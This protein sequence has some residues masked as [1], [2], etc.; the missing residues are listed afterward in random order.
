M[1]KPNQSPQFGPEWL[2]RLR[3]GDER[4]FE[5]LFRT[6]TPGLVALVT[7]YVRSR[8]VAEELVQE[9]FLTL[10]QRRL[11]LEVTQGV[12][13][14]LYVAARNRAL[15]YL[16]HERIV[17]RHAASVLG[18]LDDPASPGDADL[19]AML[20]LQDAIEELPTRCKLVYRLSRQQGMTQPEIATFLDISV[21]TVEA[22]MTRALM[23]L[24]ERLRHLLP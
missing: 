19:L 11:T 21:K 18:R 16:R 12:S 5:A 4:A 14:Y 7:R 8:S 3:A 6:F 2:A 20:E 22:H 23:I 1:G 24:R 15:A 10:W 9:L 17:E 13:T